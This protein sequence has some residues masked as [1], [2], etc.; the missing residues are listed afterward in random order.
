METIDALERKLHAARRGVPGAKYQTSLVIDLNGP[1]G[2]I[3]YLMGVCK[4]LVR[5]L[6][7]SA[8][9]KRECET[10]INSAGDY[11]SR[12]AIMQKWFGITFVE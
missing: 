8:Q 9:L 7:L 11:Q 3:F 1:A 10:E 2:N 6:G 4:R 5:E 12:L